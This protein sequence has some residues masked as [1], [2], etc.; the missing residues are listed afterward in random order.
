MK[1]AINGGIV[2]GN[3]QY[4]H[5]HMLLV[6]QLG[7]CHMAQPGADQHQGRV[8]IRETA[9][10][11]GAATN[12]PVHS[13]NDI[14]GEDASPV[15]AGKITVGEH[16]LNTILLFL[17]GLPQSHGTQFPYHSF[18]LLPGSSFALL[19]MERL[20]NDSGDFVSEDPP[21]FL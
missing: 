2:K 10:Y 13:F 18:A 20:E 14:V 12:L 1:S 6:D 11:T 8:T 17:V 5:V 16:L 3:Y 4:L 19:N 9:H 15:F 21:N 7:A